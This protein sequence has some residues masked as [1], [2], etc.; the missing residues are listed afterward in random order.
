M[1]KPALFALLL[2]GNLYAQSQPP[3]PSPLV[4]SSNQQEKAAQPDQKSGGDQRGTQQ[5]PLTVKVLPPTPTD[6]G[7]Q[8]EREDREQKATNE[9]LLVIANILLAFFTAVLAFYTIRLWSQTRRLAIGAEKAA[10]HQLRAYLGFKADNFN[11]R[12]DRSI[13]ADG[14]LTNFG[15]TP[16]RDLQMMSRLGIR[17]VG[18]IP[19]VDEL[20]PI[21]PRVSYGVLNPNDH[22]TIYQPVLPSLSVH[23]LDAVKEGTVGRI[24]YVGEVVYRDV[25]RKRW[26]LRW[27]FYVKWGPGAVR[28]W[29]ATEQ[30]NDEQPVAD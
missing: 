13:V 26:R 17:P 19:N 16:A 1:L 5:S 29:I 23:D 20:P 9:R 15:Q 22:T 24:Y 14:Q 28:T 7:A 4:R 10:E 12:V 30:H 3:A 8:Q 2:A 21:L 25:F 27:S 11:L 18:W 6:S